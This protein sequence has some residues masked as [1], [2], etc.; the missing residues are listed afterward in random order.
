M[1]LHKGTSKNCFGEVNSLQIE[2]S[3]DK[4]A[5]LYCRDAALD[6]EIVQ[7]E[8]RTQACLSMTE[9]QAMTQSVNIGH[10]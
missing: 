4:L 9:M 1:Y 5:C 2:R 8:S 10:L 6:D 3:K 7:I